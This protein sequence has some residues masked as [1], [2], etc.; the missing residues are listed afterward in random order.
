MT[1]EQ[2]A[3]KEAYEFETGKALS[4]SNFKHGGVKQ[5]MK[6]ENLISNNEELGNVVLIKTTE[7]WRF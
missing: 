1:E 2:K 5:T 4:I 7:G 6:I 3:Y